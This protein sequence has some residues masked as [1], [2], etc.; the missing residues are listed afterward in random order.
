VIWLAS[1]S[2]LSIVCII[3]VCYNPVL[4]TSQTIRLPRRSHIDLNSA[5]KIDLASRKMRGQPRAQIKILNPNTAA[6]VAPQYFLA[7]ARRKATISSAD[8]NPS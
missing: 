5:D 4:P 1:S 3:F 6:S 8:H 2:C 7:V